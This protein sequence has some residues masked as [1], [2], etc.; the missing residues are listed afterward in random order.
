MHSSTNSPAARGAKTE[1]AMQTMAARR[2]APEATAMAD[3]R[4]PRRRRSRV[5][6]DYGGMEVEEAEVRRG[7]SFRLF[8]DRDRKR[9]HGRGRRPYEAGRLERRGLWAVWLWGNSRPN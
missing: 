2:R 3:P 6:G 8:D 4:Q 1:R 7:W 5:V 9:E